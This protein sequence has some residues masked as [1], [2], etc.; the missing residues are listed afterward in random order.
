MV[1]DD[2]TA[3]DGAILL[4]L[5][6][7]AREV[8]NTEL[9]ELYGLDVRK[10]P[11]EKLEKLKYIASRKSGRTNALLLTDEGWLR[12]RE[13]LDFTLRGA[14]ALGSALKA[15]H[16]AIRNRVLTRAGCATLGELFSST[17]LRAPAKQ[18][19]RSRIVSA[20]YALADEPKDWVSLRRL[21]PFFADVARKDLDEALRR[22]IEEDNV[23]LAPESSGR[24]VTEADTEAALRVG[25][26]DNHLLAI[27][28]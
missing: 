1:D 27:G 5:M 2:L 8:L 26:Q 7:E 14:G 3:S 21:R 9:A 24:L 4:V 18:D 10:G 19:L 23:S 28:V 15:L 20:Y 25:G 16:A 22:L 13:D 12:V 11:R 17:D 6:V